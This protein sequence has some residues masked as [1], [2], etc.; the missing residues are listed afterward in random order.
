MIPMKPLLIPLLLLAALILASA[1]CVQPLDPVTEN[2]TGF[3]L[4]AVERDQVREAAAFA[5]EFPPD[6]DELQKTLPPFTQYYAF[7]NTSENKTYF[8]YLVY[9]HPES[10]AR[11]R[12]LSLNMSYIEY[13]ER[14]LTTYMYD[15]NHATNHV[16]LRFRKL[17]E[18][19]INPSLPVIHLTRE[20]VETTPLLRSYFIDFPNCGLK[21]LPE[22]EWQL[23]PYKDAQDF[24]GKA[25]IE[26]NGDYYVMNRSVA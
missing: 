7:M 20:T 21:V 2:E 13:L 6:A 1:G 15:L 23:L 9:T 19:E 3:N 4:S 26:W 11:Y 14:F 25:Y 16:P 5:A 12:N 10:Y 18:A 24:V 22:E 17:S 8:D